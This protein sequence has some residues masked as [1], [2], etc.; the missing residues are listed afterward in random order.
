MVQNGRQFGC[1]PNEYESII[2]YEVQNRKNFNV[3]LRNMELTITW[4]DKYIINQD[5]SYLLIWNIIV[6]IITV[7]SCFSNLHVTVFQASEH[8]DHDRILKDGVILWQ[9]VQ[10][11]MFGIDII[12]IFFTEIKDKE[13]GD[14]QR[15]FSKI[16]I[17]YLKTTFLIDLIAFFPFFEL[18]RFQMV[19]D[20]GKDEYNFYHLLYLLRLL[21]MY[22][23]SQL[24][25]PSY[26]FGVVKKLHKVYLRYMHEG[27][28]G[29]EL[30]D[31]VYHH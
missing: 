13:T 31:K 22:K 16:A 18:F 7:L 5:N 25:N 27:L 30:P 11:Y 3:S 21:R 28:T 6:S 29:Q 19:E 26:V 1:K 9:I 20:M 24:L 10:E 2:N 23:A 14:D 4:Y 12:I 17:E 15:L 8:H